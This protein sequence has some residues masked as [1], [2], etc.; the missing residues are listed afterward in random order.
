M[1][2]MGPGDLARFLGTM[3]GGGAAHTVSRWWVPGY[4][5]RDLIVERETLA[6]ALERLV[7]REVAGPVAQ[8]A[9]F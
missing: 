6:A 2:R 4:G 3:S 9:L 8:A 1:E 5:R 7:E